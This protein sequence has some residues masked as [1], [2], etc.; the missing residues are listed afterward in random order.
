MCFVC[1]LCVHTL[2]EDVSR[3]LFNV[4]KSKIVVCWPGKYTRMETA[5][6]GTTGVCAEN[7][8]SYELSSCYPNLNYAELAC[9][10]CDL[11]FWPNDVKCSSQKIT[12]LWK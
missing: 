9:Q 6:V 7:I 1:C 12:S 3:F 11:L 10:C 5:V 4:D 8:C 2:G